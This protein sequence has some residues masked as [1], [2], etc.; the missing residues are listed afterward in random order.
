MVRFLKLLFLLPLA[1]ALVLLAVANRQSVTLILDPFTRGPDAYSLTMPLFMLAFFILMVGIVLGYT[2][3]WL[4]QGRFR[5]EAK[6]LKRECDRLSAER[7]ILKAAAPVTSPAL[8]S[9]GS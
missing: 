7:A 8:L 5:R 4:A 1:A 2:V 3:A 9:S 6:Q